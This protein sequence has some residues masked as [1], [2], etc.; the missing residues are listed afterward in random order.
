MLSGPSGVSRTLVRFS[1]RSLSYDEDKAV[2]ATLF[3][4]FAGFQGALTGGC[5]VIETT[6]QEDSDLAEA[7]IEGSDSWTYHEPIDFLFRYRE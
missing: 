2:K 1:M 7:P 4:L 3:G 6:H 5:R